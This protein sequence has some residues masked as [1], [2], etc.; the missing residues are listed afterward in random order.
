MEFTYAQENIRL[1]LM[2]PQQ[3]LHPSANVLTF[4]NGSVQQWL[5]PHPECFLTGRVTSQSGVA[6]ISTCDKIVSFVTKEFLYHIDIYIQLFLYIKVESL[7][8][9]EI[10]TFMNICFSLV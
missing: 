8:L 6:S 9:L 4:S 10:Q 7:A 5:G 2:T 3:I 1:E